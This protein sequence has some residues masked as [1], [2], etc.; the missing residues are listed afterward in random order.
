MLLWI[1]YDIA[2]DRARARVAKYCKQAGL[3]RVQYSV[4]LGTT[5]PNDRDELELKIEA[6][7]DV[8]QDKVYV[9]PMSKDELNDTTLMG[10]AFDKQLVTDDVRALFF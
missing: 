1:L 9:F 4:F 5:T 7:I 2:N 6:E 10:Q 8:S 3:Y